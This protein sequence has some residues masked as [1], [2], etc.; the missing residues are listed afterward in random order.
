MARINRSLDVYKTT[1]IVLLLAF[2]FRRLRHFWLG[3]GVALT[4]QSTLML[5]EY[6]FAG[7]R[8]DVYTSK[9]QQIRR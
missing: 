9:I 6:L 3:F 2:Y 4:L 7:H 8:A 1:E 5:V